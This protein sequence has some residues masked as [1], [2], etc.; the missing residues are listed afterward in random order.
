[1]NRYK[2]LILIG[3]SHIAISSIKE[4][5]RTILK[6]K[7]EIIALELDKKRFKALIS[8]KRKINLSIIKSIGIK[9]FLFN[10]IGSSIENKLGKLV[11]IPP[12]SEM[13]KAI[14]LAKKNNSKIALIDQ[15]IE[16]TLKKLSKRITWKEKFKF[17][18]EVFKVLIYKKPKIRINLKEVPNEELINKLTKKFQKDYPSFYQ[19]LVKE[20][21]EI[22]AKNLY[23]L[24]TDNQNKKIVAIVGAG[25]EKEIINLIKGELKLNSANK[26]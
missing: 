21:D 1:M 16:I 14:E 7:P 25:H 11:G 10:L 22:M 3:S 24:M 8:K 6:I 26:K 23:N 20:R 2:N 4:V 19:T 18:S 13:K 12:G 17:I 9:G 15:D 5:E